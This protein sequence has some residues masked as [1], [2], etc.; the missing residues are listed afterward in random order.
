M[1]KNDLSFTDLL[2]ETHIGLERQGPGSPQT[3]NRALGFLGNLE[4]FAQTADLGCGTGG[5][6]MLLAERLPGKIVGLDL[7]PVFVDELN[8]KAAAKNL[9]DRVKGMAGRMEDLPFSENQ[10]DLIWSEGAVDNIGF[11]TGL[12]HWRRFLKKGGYVAVSSPSWLT[13]EQPRVVERFWSE[14]GSRLDTVQ[15]NIEAM[16]DCGY[17]F[18]ASFALEEECWTEHYFTPREA[19]IRRLLEKYDRSDTMKAYAELNRR[20]V[21]L[22]LRYNEHCGYVFYIGRAV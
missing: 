18:V 3:V 10:F 5:Q 13:K 16:Q 7:F 21:E 2:I 1:E 17:A 22:Y 15:T 9:G 4:R 11:R 8:R 19:A 6:T 12:A 20:E 14:A